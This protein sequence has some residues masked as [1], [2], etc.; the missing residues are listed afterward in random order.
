MNG[1]V[2]VWN[3]QGHELWEHH[4]GSMVVQ[5]FNHRKQKEVIVMKENILHIC[6]LRI[7]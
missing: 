6:Y 5:V 3:A 1:N 7:S 2:A 4:V